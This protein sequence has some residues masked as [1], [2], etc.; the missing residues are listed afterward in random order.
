MTLD[1]AIQY[2]EEV[3]KEKCSDEDKQLAEWLKELKKY[4]EQ[5]MARNKMS[6]IAAMFGKE[7]GEWFTIN[8]GGQYVTGQFMLYGF[9]EQ[10]EGGGIRIDA[11]KLERLLI[12]QVDIVEN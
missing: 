1:E 6:A 7:I 9:M 3:A 8:Y 12:G 2:Y 11:T 5:L 4:K 10:C